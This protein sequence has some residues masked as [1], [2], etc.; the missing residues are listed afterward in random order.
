[1]KF[2]EIAVGVDFHDLDFELVVRRVMKQIQVQ[3]KRYKDDNPQIHDFQ[4]NK[5]TITGYFNYLI[6]IDC[7]INGNINLCKYLSIDESRV[8]VGKE[9]VD[10]HIKDKTRLNYDFY[11]FYSP[12]GEITRHEI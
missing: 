12:Y 6:S 10:N 5:T 9:E 8:F 7:Y 2:E 4:I 3:L 11:C 1:M